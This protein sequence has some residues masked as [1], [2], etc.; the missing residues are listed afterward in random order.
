[1][2]SRAPL[3]QPSQCKSS[4]TGSWQ[5]RMGSSSTSGDKTA[6]GSDEP[7]VSHC[8]LHLKIL[9]FWHELMEEAYRGGIMGLALFIPF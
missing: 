2:N 7:D 1:M 4:I 8:H 3:G 5:G 9:V 6:M